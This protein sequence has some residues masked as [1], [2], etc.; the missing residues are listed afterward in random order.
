MTTEV[1]PGPALR[2]TQKDMNSAARPFGEAWG[3]EKVQ[4]SHL[5]MLTLGL[6]LLC[7]FTAWWGHKGWSRPAERIY[8]RIDEVGRASVVPG[9]SFSYQP[10]ENEIKYHMT[11]FVTAFYSRRRYT[12]AQELPRSLWYLDAPLRTQQEA[13]INRAEIVKAAMMSPHDL[14]VQVNKV[15][16]TQTETAPYGLQVD[17]SVKT[18]DP[19]SRT[20]HSTRHYT[21]TVQYRFADAIPNA[22]VPFNP[23]GIFITYLRTDEAFRGDGR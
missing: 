2:V 1:L 19:S 16:L 23:L 9:A 22:L 14:E 15:T 8:V 12:V 7:G 6:L 4:N 11:Q 5:R 10:R 20:V 13:E 18:V 21:A 3:G 17:Y